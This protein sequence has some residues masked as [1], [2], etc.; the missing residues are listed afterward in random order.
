MIF[1]FVSVCVYGY[2]CIGMYINW[3]IYTYICVYMNIYI[4]I[5]IHIYTYIRIYICVC[6]R[7]RVC[8][9]V[10]VCAISLFLV[11]VAFLPALTSP[12]PPP[13]AAGIP[14]ITSQS[15]GAAFLTPELEH[16]CR[17]PPD[18]LAG[19]RNDTRWSRVLWVPCNSC[20]AS[21]AQSFAFLN[22]VYKWI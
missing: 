13:H 20:N 4:W 19:D 3:C 7:A 10:C 17:P 8:V 14:Q 5:C 9:R 16:W 18:A 12:P 6:A 22:L 1:H 15:M 11:P 21:A 2:V